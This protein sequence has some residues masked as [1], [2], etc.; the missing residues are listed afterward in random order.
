VNKEPAVSIDDHLFEPRSGVATA[1]DGLAGGVSPAI[2]PLAPLDNGAYRDA[3]VTVVSGA[4]ELPAMEVRVASTD[5]FELWRH[6]WQLIVRHRV[7][8]CCI[9]DSLSTLIND[10]LFA[11]GWV[12]GSSVFESIFTGVVLTSR[13]D[14]IEAW[15]LFYS[16]TI[17]RYERA[18]PDHPGSAK[19][20]HQQLLNFVAIH[21]RADE[22]VPKRASVLEIGACFGFLSLFLARSPMRT[23]IASDI[24]PGTVRLLAAVAERLGVHLET[25][26]ADAARIP[27][28]DSSIDVVLLIHL[29]EH[30]EPR[31]GWQA[32]E[33][34]LRVA[35]SR[36]IIAVPYESAATVAYGHLRTVDETQLRAWG[37]QATGWDHSVDEYH[38][39]WLILD[40][41]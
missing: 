19:S 6:G 22:L 15:L 16:N 25:F 24:S 26:V 37:E 36:V 41:R 31:H 8:D 28:P 4:M 35:A 18:E 11:P 27:R 14:P 39:G 23:V 30:L 20:A 5:S 40:R 34:A 10:E 1:L 3:L 38:G 7:P 33:E 17:G 13:P 29:L 32:I 9:D 21:R 2:D 12:N